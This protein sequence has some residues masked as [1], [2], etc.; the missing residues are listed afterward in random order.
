MSAAQ[1]GLITTTSTGAGPANGEN[2]GE[3]SHLD[4]LFHSSGWTRQ[5]VR[6]IVDA[7]QLLALLYVVYAE[8]L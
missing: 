7:L 8:V 2:A 4:S 6:L 5:D 3:L 1:S